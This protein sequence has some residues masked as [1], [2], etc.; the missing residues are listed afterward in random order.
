[1]HYLGDDWTN[2]HCL[3]PFTIE[4]KKN[5][6]TYYE[7]DITVFLELHH[8]D[9]NF[10]YDPGETKEGEQMEY[11]TNEFAFSMDP[12]E[13]GRVI[14][15]IDTWRIEPKKHDG[16][17]LSRDEVETGK[18]IAVMFSLFYGRLETD[19]V[20]PDNWHK[21][22]LMGKPKLFKCIVGPGLPDSICVEIDGNDAINITNGNS[23]EG[24]GRR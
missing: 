18:E 10:I 12:S 17:S 9:F 5:D 24:K 6:G 8:D 21:G 20:I 4:F 16:S 14:Y 1:M 19:D 23:L 2:T 7:E 3:P 11:K 15:D 13:G 22:D